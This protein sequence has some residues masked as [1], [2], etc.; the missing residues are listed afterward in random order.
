[1]IFR[2]D[3]GLWVKRIGKGRA[4][5]LTELPD[6]SKTNSVFSSDSKRVAAIVQVEGETQLVAIDVKSGRRTNLAS[7]ADL[8]EGGSEIGPVISWQPVPGR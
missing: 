2:R 4:R 1:M 6:G 5:K 8:A 7:G 3:R